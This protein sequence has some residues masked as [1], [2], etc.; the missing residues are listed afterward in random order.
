MVSTIP[1][2]ADIA[3]LMTGVSEVI[4]NK[5]SLLQLRQDTYLPH[6]HCLTPFFT[7]SLE[8]RQCI[9]LQNFQVNESTDSGDIYSVCS[10]KSLVSTVLL[11]TLPFN[12]FYYYHFTSA[13][14]GHIEIMAGCLGFSLCIIHINSKYNNIHEHDRNSLMNT[15]SQ[16]KDITCFLSSKM[17]PAIYPN[18]SIKKFLQT[19]KGHV[20]L[21]TVNILSLHVWIFLFLAR[22]KKKK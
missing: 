18:P 7:I 1:L 14:Q 5:S 17:P 3:Q 11:L 10:S 2:Q 21:Y 6:S 8:W 16:R 19:I 9:E 12:H 4:H 22:V 20:L 13:S 15:I